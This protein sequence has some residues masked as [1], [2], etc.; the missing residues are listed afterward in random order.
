MTITVMM[1]IYNNITDINVFVNNNSEIRIYANTTKAS[2]EDRHQSVS[3]LLF[4][5]EHTDQDE[6]N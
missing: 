5:S 1:A 3:V 2:T 4:Y 6:N